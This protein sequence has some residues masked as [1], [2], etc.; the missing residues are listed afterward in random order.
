MADLKYT[1]VKT[2]LVFPGDGKY[3]KELNLIEWGDHKAKYDVRGWSKDR[4]DMTKGV[5]LTPE[6][7]KILTE[8]LAVLEL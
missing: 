4:S 6:E 7:M 5:T 1:I 3:H 2:L 8:T